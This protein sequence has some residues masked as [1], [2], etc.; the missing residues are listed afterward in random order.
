MVPTH[1]FRPAHSEMRRM[2]IDTV[3]L[4]RWDLHEVPADS[5]PVDEGAVSVPRLSE[6][7][8]GESSCGESSP[9]ASA[10]EVS[11]PQPDSDGR[12]PDFVGMLILWLMVEERK[13]GEKWRRVKIEVKTKKT[14]RTVRNILNF[15]HSQCQYWSVLPEASVARIFFEQVLDPTFLGTRFTK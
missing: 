2:G 1:T 3:S 13:A 10:G 9:G 15:T 4:G 6:F 14:L 12:A 7:A 5:R 8:P 11:V